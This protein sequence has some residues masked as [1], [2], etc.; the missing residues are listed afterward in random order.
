VAFVYHRFFRLYTGFPLK[1]S[2]VFTT[3]TEILEYTVGVVTYIA[4][5]GSHSIPA[6]QAMPLILEWNVAVL[7]LW[8]GVLHLHPRRRGLH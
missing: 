2:E 5:H 4:L 3:L 7:F 8:G 1:I 6:I